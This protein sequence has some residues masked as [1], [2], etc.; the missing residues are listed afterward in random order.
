MTARRHLT[1]L[2]TEAVMRFA[3]V[4]IMILVS[5]GCVSKVDGV[6]PTTEGVE[7]GAPVTLVWVGRG[8]VER[9]EAGKWQRAPAF[10][11][12]FTVEQRRYDD[13]WESVK[14]LK[15]RHPAYD[16]SAGPREETMYFRVDLGRAGDGPVALR[17]T[18]TL[19]PGEG[20]TDSE[21]REAKLVLHPDISSFAPFDTYRIDQQYQYEAGKL[22]EVVRLDKGDAPW[23]RSHESATLFAPHRFDSPPT[24]LAVSDAAPRR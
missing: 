9:L 23:V 14:H 10:D 2:S 1:L 22:T 11:Y 19:G 12:E 15:R 20:K 5:V 7:A 21:F 16:G 6:L 18:T 4:S 24:R 13:H 8:E 3:M 17:L